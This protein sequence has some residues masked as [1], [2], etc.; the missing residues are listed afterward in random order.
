MHSHI[1]AMWG[2][3]LFEVQAELKDLTEGFQVPGSNSGFTMWQAPSCEDTDP[4]A[5]AKGLPQESNVLRKGLH[6]VVIHAAL[7]IKED[8]QATIVLPHAFSIEDPMLAALCD[9]WQNKVPW[10]IV[11][12]PMGGVLLPNKG[13]QA[14]HALHI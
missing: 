7:F 6:Q 10:L 13:N 5:W 9:Y 8:N 3:A 1:L 2:K 14:M 4:P 11:F 12:V